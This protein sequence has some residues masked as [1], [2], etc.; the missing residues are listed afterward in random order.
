MTLLHSTGTDSS[1]TVECD[2]SPALTGEILPPRSG[3]LHVVAAPH[4]FSVMRLIMDM[5]SGLTLAD[6]LAKVQPEPSLRRFA[7]IAIGDHVIAQEDFHRIRPKPGTFITIRM[8]PGKKVAGGGGGTGKGK[9]PLA[10]IL[11]I[12][13]VIAAIA[14]P[15]F[16][17]AALGLVAGST[18]ALITGG[19]LAGGIMIAGG[20]LG[21]ALAPP[22]KPKL[23]SLAAPV[24][25]ANPMSQD[26]E[27]P[28]L[29]ISGARN[30]LRPYSPV[31][32]VLGKHW[33]VPALGAPTYTEILG[34][35]QYLHMVVVWGVGPLEVST[36]KIGET[37]LSS[38]QD[39][40][41]EFRRGYQPSQIHDR[42]LWVSTVFPTNP[43]FGDRWT[44]N[45]DGM[46]STMAVRAGDT[47]TYNGLANPGSATA[48]DLN[49][50]K[51]FDLFPTSVVE[52]AE[53]II[54]GMDWQQ[55]TTAPDTDRIS[56]DFVYYRGLV[57]FDDQG[58]RIPH[59]ATMWSSYAPA[60]TG[61]WVD[62]PEAVST[63]ATAEA[64]RVGV[65]VNVPRG[66]YDVRWRRKYA[67]SVDTRVI[68]DCAVSTLR[69][70]K[71]EAP[72]D[73]RGGIS[74]PAICCQTL[75]IRATDQLQGAIDTLS[76]ICQSLVPDWNGT[77]WKVRGTSNPASLLRWVYQGPGNHVPVSDGE[78]EI[79]QIRHW[80]DFCAAK[81]FT[82]NHV[83]DYASRV[84]QIASDIASAGRASVSSMD[85]RITIV[86]DEPATV[87][88]QVF[89][90][91]N[92]WGFRS[93][94]TYPD[95]PHA[96]RVR[97]VDNL[98]GDAR[99]I[100][101]YD[102]GY[103]AENATLFEVLPLTGITDPRH[104]HVQAR[105]H[106]A[107]ARLRRESVSFYT[108]FEGRVCTRGD[109]IRFNHDV[110]L[111]G[112][113]SGKVV[114]AISE[115][116][117]VV[118][119]VLDEEVTLEQGKS[120]TIRFRRPS[121]TTLEVYSSVILRP[122]VQTTLTFP[123]IPPI[124]GEPAVK[125]DYLWWFGETGQEHRNLR[126]HA[127]VDPSPEHSVRLIC[128]EDN[129][130]I[131]DA[132]LA[133]I[134]PYDPGISSGLSILY[135]RIIS[136]RSDGSV[137]FRKPDGT[138]DNRILITYTQPSGTMATQIRG[139]ECS[140]KRVSVETWSWTY[141]SPLVTG[142]ISIRDVDGHE[143]YH[144]LLR[145]A[146]KDGTFGIWSPLVTHTVVANDGVPPD[147]PYFVVT[148]M[149]DG[150][151]RF[152]WRMV[153]E[154]EDVIAGGGYRIR[155]QSGT[156]FTWETAIQ[157]A[158]VGLLRSSPYETN[159]VPAGVWTFGIKAVTASGMESTTARTMTVELGDPRMRD[160]LMTTHE[161][162][163][164]WPGT[165]TD[166]F[167]W[168]SEPR[169]LYAGPAEGAL[170]YSQGAWNTMETWED[171]PFVSPISY[172]TLVLSPGDGVNVTYTPRIDVDADGDVT[173]EMRVGTAA[174]G[175]NLS[176][177]A[178]GP[179][180]Q[181][182]QHAYIQIKVTSDGPRIRQ[183]IINIDGQVGVDDIEDINTLTTSET[184]FQRV[185]VG[186]FRVAA[187]KPLAA[188]TGAS[189][190][191]IQT[192]GTNWTWLLFSKTATVAGNTRPAAEFKIYDN[193]ILTDALVDVELKGPLL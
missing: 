15:P 176:A 5:E 100:F 38:F 45:G 155:R 56:F 161:H 102:D 76:G 28:T 129:P 112:L 29:S 127:M 48:W 105:Y 177:L 119:A 164:G 13:T 118:S 154:P 9:N 170:W 77:T 98:T 30:D 117:S 14:I 167:V 61:A 185:G 101:V 80:H 175:S 110:P 97:F 88:V 152:E 35:D 125:S 157:L 179:V 180:A 24:G 92:S 186:H 103:S 27:S 141:I 81:S 144:I 31:A 193:K 11:S 47:I 19:L 136:I 65:A 42:G 51:L 99:E 192:P 46:I 26:A 184:W 107:V 147:V 6:I 114:E 87:P 116:N 133:P 85:T 149:P 140:F 89:T 131:Y 171:L 18:G 187:R 20:M 43:E 109:L 82:F 138:Y 83:V 94:I 115:N 12:V 75:K 128:V 148:R 49:E 124:N 168:G 189:I 72:F 166:C 53:Q 73:H 59:D 134:P 191:A 122:G 68:D 113:K 40:E 162:L 23:M 143:T 66:Q 108:D 123:A 37:L 74:S 160:S 126:V 62:F 139:V 32:L 33:Q 67:V 106:L 58:I 4:P 137:V 183:L 79:A 17:V 190:R 25:N 52:T 142:D 90:P 55:R 181:V 145:F 174:Y 64:L 188:I 153:L 151:R 150:T 63:A 78:I 132:E 7:H 130:A 111:W 50:H 60:G 41:T 39:V 44:V 21:N 8:L 165:K 93:E 71:H 96:Y 135:P 69:S 121:G 54:M 173:V 91:R 104:A 178:W 3:L 169:H 156:S 172:T 159:D 10:T 1:S 70:I 182:V 84:E 22:A 146:R 16:A 2:D 57:R 34:P 95:L 86:I 163:V 158:D 120:Y 36:L